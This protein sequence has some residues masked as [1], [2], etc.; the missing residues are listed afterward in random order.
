[1]DGGDDHFMVVTE[2][3]TFQ[4]E[5]LDRAREREAGQL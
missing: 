2:H 5:T 1:M 4:W 3:G